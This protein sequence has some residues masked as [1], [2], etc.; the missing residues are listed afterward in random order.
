MFLSKLFKICSC[1]EGLSSNSFM[2]RPLQVTEYT[3]GLLVSHYSSKCSLKNALTKQILLRHQRSGH[4]IMKLVG[5]T[6]GVC[7]CPL[8]ISLQ[9]FAC[10]F[11]CFFFVYLEASKQVQKKCT[12]VYT[13]CRHHS[14]LNDLNSSN[15]N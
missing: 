11:S 4:T 6:A 3:F 2:A 8:P 13:N 9:Q 14:L 7:N 1:V 15:L 5:I 12:V 10:I